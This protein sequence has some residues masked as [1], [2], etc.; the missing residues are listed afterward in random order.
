MKKSSF[1]PS[2]LFNG[3]IAPIVP[4]T[5]KGFI[6]YQGE[7]NRGKFKVYKELFPSLIDSWRK[8]WKNNTLPFYY[9]QLAP[10]G[11]NENPRQD[12][13][14]AEFRD[15][16]RKALAKSNLGMAITSE[17]GHPRLIQAPKNKTISFNNSRAYLSFDHV[18]EGLHSK[19]KFLKYFEI[20]DK[21]KKFYD[22]NAVIKN[23]KV[24]VWSKKI[25]NP[26]F[27][28]Y[29][30]KSYFKPNFFNKEG[31]PASSFSTINEF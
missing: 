17:I 8:E 18:G 11:S 6:W 3:M 4:Y 27:V 13:I 21:D 29:G 19:D 12:S 9:V 10:V 25:S 24:I 20:A 23:N 5:L 26:K 7:S 1:S 14:H 22:A 30:W 16:Q 2:T 28:R 31:L 15:V